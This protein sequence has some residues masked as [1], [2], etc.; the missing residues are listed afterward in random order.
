[1]KDAPDACCED[2]GQF[3]DAEEINVESFELTGRLLCEG[4]AQE[5][6]DMEE[7]EDE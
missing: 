3:M 6:L 2:C 7:D 5:A 4:C 1:M